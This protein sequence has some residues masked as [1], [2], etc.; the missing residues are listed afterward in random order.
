M[1]GQPSYRIVRIVLEECRVFRTK[2]RA[3]SLIV[4][5]VIRE[6]LYDDY[7][8]IKRR[9][10][11][12]TMKINANS[13]M[14]LEEGATV[15]SLNSPTEGRESPIPS[16]ST[17]KT[18]SPRKNISIINKD[19]QSVILGNLDMN[20]D[21]YNG[22]SKILDV[23]EKNKTQSTTVS[24]DGSQSNDILHVHPSQALHNLHLDNK[25]TAPQ[26]TLST[27]TISDSN[28]EK[29]KEVDSSNIAEFI[30][31]NDIERIQS[32][33]V[34]DLIALKLTNARIPHDNNKKLNYEN[35][36]MNKS[37]I[38]INNGDNFKGQG[39]PTGHSVS[40]SSSHANRINLSKRN[41][42][43]SY[44][45][46]NRKSIF[47]FQN[48]LTSAS[49]DDFSLL[50]GNNEKRSDIF[51][52]TKELSRTDYRGSSG[53]LDNMNCVQS[54]KDRRSGQNNSNISRENDSNSSLVR[55]KENMVQKELKLREDKAEEAKYSLEI[56]EK[57][58]AVNQ[59]SD[60]LVHNDVIP[61]RDGGG[62]AIP[63][64]NSVSGIS[65]GNNPS[66][67]NGSVVDN[68][69]IIDNSTSLT[70]VDGA[71]DEVANTGAPIPTLPLSRASSPPFSS[72]TEEED[73]NL[74]TIN[75]YYNIAKDENSDQNDSQMTKNDIIND[76]VNSTN[77]FVLAIPPSLAPTKSPRVEQYIKARVALI[78]SQEI[79]KR[80]H[81]LFL[82]NTTIQACRKLYFENRI[83]EDEY[84][85]LIRTEIVFLEEKERNEAVA[86]TLRYF[87]VVLLLL[88]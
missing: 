57:D 49:T 51:A 76:A 58:L 74:N 25:N 54:R 64:D 2:A 71:V 44:L 88:L 22:S 21:N 53:S 17:K 20:S 43:S 50:V 83:S 81:Q 68:E 42:S 75:N 24:D 80:A 63:T 67:I 4:C 1:A 84:E 16:S 37:D 85:K 70:S 28:S 35:S 11:A 12:F 13:K 9:N 6:D 26:I 86:A 38:N 14:G 60:T 31:R 59:L 72:P 40:S 69:A 41:S 18:Q 8:R 32:Q 52:K 78:P 5:E 19:S 66:E 73:D 62:D 65:E 55:L 3:P 36:N 46:A 61:E 56:D 79:F 82:K 30:E 39:S 27:N 48:I 34:D 29:S 45:S 15:S 87:V 77:S 33:N 47:N 7:I 10:D 23:G